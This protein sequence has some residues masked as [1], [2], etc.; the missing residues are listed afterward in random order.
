MQQQ[1]PSLPTSYLGKDIPL[2]AIEGEFCR[3]ITFVPFANIDK[4][5]AVQ[6][7]SLTTPYALL[8][9]ESPKLPKDTDC[10]YLVSHKEDFR[11]IYEAFQEIDSSTQEVMIVYQHNPYKHQRNIWVK[12]SKGILPKLHVFIYKKGGLEQIYDTRQQGGL[13]RFEA[14]KNMKVKEWTPV[15]GYSD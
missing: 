5:G 3:V 7:M 14:L 4:K 11:H 10:I 12:L 1:T 15:D 2:E 8:H 9:V 6:A 13:E